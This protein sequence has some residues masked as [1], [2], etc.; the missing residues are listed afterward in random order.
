MSFQGQ[1]QSLP[2]KEWKGNAKMPLVIMY[3][4]DGGL[5]SFTTSLGEAIHANGYSVVI[6]N[7]R[8][9]FWKK[10]TPDQAT[11]DLSAFLKSAFKNLDHPQWILIGYS[12]GADITPFVVNR[13]PADLGKKLSSILLLQPS[14]TTEFEIKLTDMLG[15]AKKKGADVLSEV[16]GIHTAKT[17]VF[18][19]DNTGGFPLDQI[20]NKWVQVVR[21]GGDHHFGGDTKLLSKNIL[22]YF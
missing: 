14:P 8:S 9:Y 4:G 16:N 22:K 19:G 13:L 2:I 6:V 3:S 20:R 1:A 21:L 5:N 18:L 10:K 15:A 17:T 7:S 11:A 12:F